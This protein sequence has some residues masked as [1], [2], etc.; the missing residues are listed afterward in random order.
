MKHKAWVGHDSKPQADC[1]T[2]VGGCPRCLPT[3][4]AQHSA[5]HRAD[6]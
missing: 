2:M 4:Y 1:E 5:R 6:R 3:T